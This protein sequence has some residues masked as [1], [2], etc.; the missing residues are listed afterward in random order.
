ML[1]LWIFDHFKHKRGVS[2]GYKKFFLV[3]SIYTKV[4]LIEE[5]IPRLPVKFHRNSSINTPRRAP[6]VNSTLSLHCSDM[7]KVTELKFSGL[8]HKSM[9]QLLLTMVNVKKCFKAL[10]CMFS[11]KKTR[12]KSGKPRFSELSK[13]KVKI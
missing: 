2:R 8:K 9:R 5:V 7:V 13:K 4:K 10:K 12:V 3:F 1:K 11:F 6:N